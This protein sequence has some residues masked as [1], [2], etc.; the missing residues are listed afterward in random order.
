MIFKLAQNTTN[1]LFTDIEPEE[2]LIITFDGKG[3]FFCQEKEKKD[4]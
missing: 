2:A 4:K 1:K 3:Q